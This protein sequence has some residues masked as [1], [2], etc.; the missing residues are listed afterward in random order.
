MEILLSLIVVYGIVNILINGSILNSF[1]DYIL[2]KAATSNNK[3]KFLLIKFHKLLSCVMC[4]SFW[5]GLLVG[6][7]LGPFVGIQMIFNGFFYSG[8]CWILNAIVQFLGNG[9]DPARTMNIIIDKDSKINFK[10]DNNE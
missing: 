3:V 7:F 10:V 9:Y 4:S 6:F 5:V 1:R 8:A 2:Q